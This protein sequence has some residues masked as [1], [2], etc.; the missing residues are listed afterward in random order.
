MEVLSLI[1][2]DI[3]PHG[4]IQQP[5]FLENGQKLDLLAIFGY[6]GVTWGTFPLTQKYVR[7]SVYGDIRNFLE[8]CIGGIFSKKFR[9]SP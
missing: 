7:G 6:F 5:K 4:N 9:I 8:K 3:S 2:V 1:S